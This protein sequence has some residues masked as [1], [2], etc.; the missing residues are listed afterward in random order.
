MKI[1]DYG[2][3]INNFGRYTRAELEFVWNILINVM[4][5]FEN[6]IEK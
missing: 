1:N 2:L 5:L 4:C 3:I 6:R